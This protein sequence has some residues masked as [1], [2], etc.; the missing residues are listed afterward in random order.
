MDRV[1]EAGVSVAS[2]SVQSTTLDG[3]FVH[4]TG[5]QLRDALLRPDPV[6]R[7]ASRRALGE[8][9]RDKGTATRSSGNAIIDLNRRAGVERPTLPDG[10]CGDRMDY[11]MAVEALFAGKYPDG[12]RAGAGGPGVALP[13]GP[14][15]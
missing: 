2:L 8:R 9:R 15:A 3:V 11:G 5:R 12:F 1:H 14:P 10:W 6:L 7:L 13:V 4:Y